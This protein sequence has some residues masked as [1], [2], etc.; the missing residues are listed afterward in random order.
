LQLRY[1][2]YIVCPPA[3]RLS[4]FSFFADA[5]EEWTTDMNRIMSARSR[6]VRLALTLATLLALGAARPWLACASVITV[7]NGADLNIPGLCNLR[8]AIYSHNESTS[9]PLSSCAEGNRNK[10]DTIVLD[11]IGN[12]VDVGRPLEPIEGGTTG[13][14]VE[15][16]PKQANVCYNLRQST[17]LTIDGGATL[18]LT[19]ISVVVNGAEFRSV[20]GT[21]GGN[22]IIRPNGTSGPCLFSN[23][24][25]RDRK[26]IN[27]GILYVEL[28]TATIDANF[29]NSS[30]SN[31]GGAIY[32]ANKGVATITGGAINGNNAQKGGA[33][34]VSSGATLNIKSSNFTINNNSAS[35]AGG[36]I[37]SDGGNVT[38]QRD[39]SQ[40]L[41]SVQIASNGALF[42]GGGVFANGGKLS[43]DGIQFLGN[44]STGFTD[45]FPGDGGAIQLTNFSAT[46]PASITRTYFRRNLATGKGGSI[47]ATAG[48]TLTLSGDTF[49]SNASRAGGIVADEEASLGVINSTF[50]GTSSGQ[51][52]INLASGTADVTFSTILSSNLS[53]PASG[54][55][56]SSSVLNDVTCTHVTDDLNNLRDTASPSC[57]G[58]ND[59]NVRLD[60]ALKDNGGFTPTIALLAGSPAFDAVPVGDCVDLSGKNPLTTDQ[61]DAPRP[62][63]KHPSFCD[64]GA[65]ESESMAT[66]GLLP[67]GTPLN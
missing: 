13:A 67:P 46:N 6:I 15:I 4:D 40:P 30:A 8:Q 14:G 19:G 21:I 62:D 66:S 43:I 33:V 10:N 24:N 2:V 36:A 1:R 39:P 47:Y 37:Y 48:S 50:V 63:P 16:K 38:I 45:I 32:L 26:Q 64:T 23:Q 17:Y 53:G 31:F 60:T 44:A 49:L 3:C 27:G 42:N 22:L 61:R 7:N 25:G 56:L 41:G 18:T 12:T 52:G 35:V 57:P 20:I 29:E 65:V 58:A 59:S 55:N 34:Y 28:G 5:N 51:D 54:F 9:A 11:I